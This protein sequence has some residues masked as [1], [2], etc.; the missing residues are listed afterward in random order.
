MPLVITQKVEQFNANWSSYPYN[1]IVL[2]DTFPSDN[3]QVM[4]DTI[5]GTFWHEITH[6]ITYNMKHPFWKSLDI[7]FG[8][9]FYPGSLTVTRGM[10]EGAAVAS[11][12]I[13][14]EGRLNSEFSKHVIKQAKIEGQFPYYSDVQGASDKY[15]I[16]LGIFLLINCSFS[17]MVGP[18]LNEDLSYSVKY[19]SRL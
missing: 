15:P 10:A 6:S 3:L 12:S 19:C 11:E 16:F 5:L 9:E 1:H 18:S 17:S 8:D 2:Y 4:E 14:G 13:T 7:V